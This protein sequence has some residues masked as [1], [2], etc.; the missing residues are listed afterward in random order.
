MSDQAYMSEIDK[1]ILKSLVTSRSRVSSLTLS[2]SL[3][4][5]LTTVQRRRKRL[6]N[7][8]VETLHHMKLDIFGWRL[9]QLLI[10]TRSGMIKSV[11]RRLLSLS[12]VMSVT[13]SIGEHTIDL[14]VEI[15]FK[16][17]KELVELIDQI[18]AMEEVKDV[19]WTEK[20]E[21]LGR[22]DDA[23]VPIIDKL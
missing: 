3:E 6:E 16:D 15:V 12:Q 13:R 2:R 19:V 17:N 5:P 1:K 4:I 9:G 18:K 14:C 11:G 10:S 22:N 7:E 20:I 23:L 21:T 8:Y